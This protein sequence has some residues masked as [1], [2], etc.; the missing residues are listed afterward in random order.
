MAN[1]GFLDKARKTF[2]NKDID[3][4]VASNISRVTLPK[5][6]TDA[7][8]LLERKQ[9]TIAYD[10]T[11]ESLVVDDGSAFV[12]VSGG[13]SGGANDTLSNLS[14][15]TAVNQNLIFDNG[16]TAT[17][18]T[19]E[20]SI[21]TKIIQ[22][23]TG[24]VV[25]SGQSGRMVLATGASDNSSTG[26]IDVLS[27]NSNGGTSGRINIATGSSDGATTG[28]IDI[29]TGAPSAVDVSSGRISLLTGSPT[30]VGNSGNATVETG[31]VVDGSSGSVNIVTGST[32]G[33][34]NS[35][36]VNIS[37]GILG[38]AGLR[39]SILMD[40]L[41]VSL[42]TGSGD[43]MAPAGSAYYNSGTNKLR[44]YDGSSWVDL[45]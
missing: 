29:V 44:L 42:P 32:G 36:N 43:P 24:N 15:P 33:I 4:S 7:L 12:P 21:A 39:G 11:L 18:Q 38:G 13:G 37:T 16:G 6:S 2:F 35:G 3:G 41:Y 25:G 30:G 5:A 26:R 20:D 31:T 19:K 28:R 8:A 23:L 10:T 45:N 27:G 40:A 34:G 1:N 14:S 22:L 9:A 17:I